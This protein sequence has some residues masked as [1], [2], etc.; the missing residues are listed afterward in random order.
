MACYYDEHNCKPLA[1]GEQPDEL[2]HLARLLLDTGVGIELQIEFERLFP[3]ERGKPPAS[4]AAISKLK[5]VKSFSEGEKCPICLKEYEEG[6][7]VKQLPCCHKFHF[8]CVLP[9]LGKTNTCP[10]CRHELDT[11]DQD[12]EEYK[13]QKLQLGNYSQV[14]NTPDFHRE[15]LGLNSGHCHSR[16]WSFS[17]LP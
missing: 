15:D 4:K 10:V 16:K 11:D 5:T 6:E 12:Y 8:S 3:G 7:V 9:W 13:R 17:G 1:Y 14:D 2:L